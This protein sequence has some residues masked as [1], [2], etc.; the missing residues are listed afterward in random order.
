M[1]KFT[2]R[3]A[4]NVLNLVVVL[5]GKRLRIEVENVEKEKGEGEDNKNG[6]RKNLNGEGLLL[7]E[8]EKDY[9]RRRKKRRN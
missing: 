7:T 3:T 8:W 2:I 1:R 6:V 4:V 5:F 9:E